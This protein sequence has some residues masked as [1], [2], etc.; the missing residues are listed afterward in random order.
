[1]GI[2]TSDSNEALALLT[3]T[4]GTTK[5]LVWS[6]EG[7]GFYLPGAPGKVLL[8]A[9]ALRATLSS[10]KY[11]GYFSESDILRYQLEPILLTD[12]GT[13]AKIKAG[14]GPNFLNAVADFYS[15]R[16]DVQ[17]NQSNKQSDEANASAYR[18]AAGN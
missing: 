15:T 11:D 1:M 9:E 7:N 8:S 12:P 18:A 4:D 13:A 6:T 5:R 10:E 16:A 2:W 17:V 3:L 14:A